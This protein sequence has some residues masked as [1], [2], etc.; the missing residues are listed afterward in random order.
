MAHRGFPA[1]SRTVRTLQCGPVHVCEHRCI[2]WEALVSAGV[3]MAGVTDGSHTG[4]CV[5]LC[6]A[7]RAQR[8]TTL[9]ACGWSAAFTGQHGFVWRL[10]FPGSHL[11]NGHP[12]G[13]R[14]LCRVRA[15]YA[16]CFVCCNKPRMLWEGVP[17]PGFHNCATQGVEGFS[18]IWPTPGVCCVSAAIWYVWH[19]YQCARSPQARRV[20]SCM[21]MPS[22]TLL[23]WCNVADGIEWEMGAWRRLCTPEPVCC[24]ATRT[25]AVN[26]DTVCS[27]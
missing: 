9:A 24:F 18:C 23:M 21:Q 6:T 22:A 5:R 15:V 26:A 4:R 17:S 1:C 13:P 10:G 20:A 16:V 19:Q 27:V 14:V 11:Q 3:L 25:I 8:S 7:Q 12:A 2:E